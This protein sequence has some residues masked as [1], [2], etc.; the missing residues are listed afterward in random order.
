MDNVIDL[1]NFREEKN[2]EKK[3][4]Y[5][6]LTHMEKILIRAYELAHEYKL[7]DRDNIDSIFTVR[8]YR[9]NL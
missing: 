2:S 5:N 4:K 1:K 9:D 6:N 7:Q 3:N 8:N